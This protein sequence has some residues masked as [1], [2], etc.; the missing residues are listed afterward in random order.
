MIVR[1][2]VVFR[3]TVFGHQQQ[4]SKDCLHPDDHAKQITDTP[5]FKPFISVLIGGD[6]L[7]SIFNPFFNLFRVQEEEL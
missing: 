5:G 7:F 6:E 2:K 3:K 1:V 4:S